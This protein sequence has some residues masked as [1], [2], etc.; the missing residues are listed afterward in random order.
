MEAKTF[1]TSGLP[2]PQQ[3]DA[4]MDW[5][6]GV[7]DVRPHHAPR[8]GFRAE[9][10]SWQIGACMLSRVLAPAIRVEHN[11]T[12]I[13]RNPLGHWVI[14]LSCRSTSL[15][16]TR[17]KT[18]AV[19]PRIPF[20][21]SLADT[22]TSERPEDDRLQLYIPRDKFADLAPALDRARGTVL[23]TT[24]GL[25][26]GDYIFMLERALPDVAVSDL[27]RMSEAI[28]TMVAAC[29]ASS[30]DGAEPADPQIDMVWLER[31]RHAVRR[32]LWSPNL[33][34]S[35]LCQ[36][37]SIS[38]SKLYRLMEAEGGVSRYIQRQRLLWAYA[39]L[40]DPSIDQPVTAIADELCFADT[41][42]FSRAFRREFGAS[43][44][45]VRA[46][47]RT[48][49]NSHVPNARPNSAAAGGLYSLLRAV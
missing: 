25:L 35:M 39:S 48:A 20:V 23:D 33:G 13:R 18:L 30:Q 9:C 32:Y 45:D 36:R 21:L 15:I 49:Q 47:S 3:F 41:S 2:A 46:V 24:L 5:F 31:I 27:D 38:R 8:N 28:G 34:P 16:G 22:L 42:S 44:S 17:D 11:S 29:L 10:Q 37:L 40:S 19:S 26:L 7:F 43:P 1:S 4:W 6:N 14:T 12:H